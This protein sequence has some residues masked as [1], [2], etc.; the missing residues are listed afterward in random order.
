MVFVEL[1]HYPSLHHLAAFARSFARSRSVF[2]AQLNNLDAVWLFGPHPLSI[3]VARLCRRRGVKVFLGVRQHF[4]AYI[5]G[6]F[7]PLL[8]PIATIAAY[9]LDRAFRRLAR[10]CPTVVVGDDLGRRWQRSACA[11]LVTSFSLVA[12]E[13]LVDPATIGTRPWGDPVRL[14]TVSRLDPEKNPLL[15]PEL[16]R[17]LGPGWVIRVAGTGILSSVLSNLA[18]VLRVEG[19]IELLGHVP[20]GPALRDLY[21]ES[22]IFVHISNTEA[23]PQVLYEAMAAG[24]PIVATDVGGV[25]G[26]LAQGRRGLLVAPGSAVAISDAIRQMQTDPI[27]CRARQV[28]ALEEAARQTTDVQVTEVLA[29]IAA[30]ASPE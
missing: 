11:S 23:V 24:I 6:R 8:G 12:R 25:A 22:D 26:A 17:Q 30:N 4:P 3:S 15:I 2:A 10:H 9:A 1:P 7:P 14:L 28:E 5:R 13:D 29:F 21:R 19:Q 16:M 20:F 18:T 27:A